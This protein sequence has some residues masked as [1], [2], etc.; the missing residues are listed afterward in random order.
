MKDIG[1]SP[2]A[3]MVF[4]VGTNDIRNQVDAEQIILKYDFLLETARGKVPSTKVI[5]SDIISQVYIARR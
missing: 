4:Y 5:F 1:G 3:I 2:K